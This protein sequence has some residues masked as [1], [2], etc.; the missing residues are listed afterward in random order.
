M[1]FIYCADPMASK[2]HFVDVSCVIHHHNYKITANK[3]EQS[4][5]KLSILIFNIVFKRFVMKILLFYSIK[6]QL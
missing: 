5:L 2:N 1:G 4:F 6:A 3:L